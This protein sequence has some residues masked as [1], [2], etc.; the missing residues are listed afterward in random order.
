[1][2]LWGFFVKKLKQP[3]FLKFISIQPCWKYTV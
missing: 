3:T 1:M 2:F